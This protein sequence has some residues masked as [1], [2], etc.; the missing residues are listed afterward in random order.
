MIVRCYE[1][2]TFVARKKVYGLL[3]GLLEERKLEVGSVVG[4]PRTVDQ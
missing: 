2:R 3:V 4:S 1:L